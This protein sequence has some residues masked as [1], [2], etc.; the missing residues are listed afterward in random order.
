MELQ[1]TNGQPLTQIQYSPNQVALGKQVRRLSLAGN[2][3]FPIPDTFIIDF[4]KAIEEHAPDLTPAILKKI[5]DRML[6][7]KLPYD[8]NKGIRNIF[9]GFDSYKKSRIRFWI[10]DTASDTPKEV[11][12]DD[13]LHQFDKDIWIAFD[14]NYS[15]SPE[16]V[17][18][19]KNFGFTFFDADTMR[20]RK[21]YLEN[22]NATECMPFRKWWE[23]FQAKRE[24]H[25]KQVEQDGDE[26]RRNVIEDA[27]RHQK[28]FSAR[29][30]TK[31][32]DSF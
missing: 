6:T 29:F 15:I 5:V 9:E 8:V 26:W 31:F 7:G 21:D 27:E 2:P 4:I 19:I 23:D 32:T 24:A 30:P 16:T 1:T 11:S 22:L 3:S 12:E 17:K 28:Q 25:R 10:Y 13:D 20:R 14:N 18:A